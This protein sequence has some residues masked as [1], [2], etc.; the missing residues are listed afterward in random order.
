MEQTAFE[1]DLSS[2]EQAIYSLLETGRANAHTSRFITE[3]T[4]LSDV[5]IRQTVRDLV[6]KKGLLIA[7]AVDDPPG[8][9]IAVESDEIIT[10]TRSLRHR[11]ISILARAARLQRSSIDM[12]FNLARLEFEEKRT[13]EGV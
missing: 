1:F 4:G 3:R 13:E 8:F 10:A 6:M 7:S 11:G 12:V 5:Q 2:E 9:F